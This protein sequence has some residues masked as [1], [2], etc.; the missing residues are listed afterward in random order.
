[1]LLLKN[2]HVD[3]S[4]LQAIARFLPQVVGWGGGGGIYKV[5]LDCSVNWQLFT[6]IRHFI[7]QFSAII[8]GSNLFKFEFS[9][10]GSIWSANIVVLK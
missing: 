10:G 2:A 8:E 6:Q 9:L 1:M 7:T 5:C 4:A 3:T